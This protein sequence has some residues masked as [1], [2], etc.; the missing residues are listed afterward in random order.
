MLAGPDPELAAT[1]GFSGFGEPRGASRDGCG[2][3]GVPRVG[4]G[5]WGAGGAGVLPPKL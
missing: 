5:L 3:R 1:M 4:W 2:A